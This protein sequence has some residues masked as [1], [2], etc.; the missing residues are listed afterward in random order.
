M[1]RRL[2]ACLALLAI[3]APAFAEFDSWGSDEWDDSGSGYDAADG[4]T[5]KRQLQDVGNK[6][7]AG[8]AALEGDDW[9]TAQLQ[10]ALADDA[11]DRSDYRGEDAFVEGRTIARKCIADAAYGRENTEIACEWWAKVDYDS[12]IW[13]DPY[14]ICHEG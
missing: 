1:L 13:E 14:A 5:V 3:S 11:A 9:V 4:P 6:L 2:L 10:C 8:L 12:F 7:N